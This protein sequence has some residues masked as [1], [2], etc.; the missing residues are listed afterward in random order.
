MVMAK[1]YLDSHPGRVPLVTVNFRN[2]W[3]ETSYLVPDNL[4]GY[5]YPE[6]T[7]NVFVDDK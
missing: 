3:T 2:G 1:E 7:K 4:Y 6:A 5:G